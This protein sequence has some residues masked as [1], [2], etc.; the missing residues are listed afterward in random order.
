MKHEQ[1]VSLV[2]YLNG[3]SANDIVLTD[4]DETVMVASRQAGDGLQCALGSSAWFHFFSS[5]LKQSLDSSTASQLAVKVFAMLHQSSRVQMSLIEGKSSASISV[6]LADAILSAQ[7]R[8]V[9][10]LGITLREGAL[11]KAT[12][13]QLKE[14]GIDLSV[15][16]MVKS[17][18]FAGE[19]FK[20][21]AVTYADGI[22]YCCGNHKGHVL[23]SILKNHPQLLPSLSGKSL[24][25]IDD[26]TR[27]CDHITALF[28]ANTGMLPNIIV[29][30]YPKVTNEFAAY[31]PTDKDN[32]V[33][34][35]L[36]Q[37]HGLTVPRMG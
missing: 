18:T 21:G 1:I 9:K 37:E 13:Q 11:A 8:G 32:E 27:H 12:Q 22:I 29:R 19:I 34:Q 5:F 25:F 10:I 26:Q 28:N 23:D 14:L 30:Q 4:I 3:L 6:T 36:T 17:F 16:H 24:H 15:S 33:I 2:D 31:E 20:R 7:R 35:A